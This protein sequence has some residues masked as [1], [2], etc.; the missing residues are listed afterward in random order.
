[1]EVLNAA[2]SIHKP[3]ISVDRRTE[4]KKVFSI[5]SSFTFKYP[6]SAKFDAC[7]LNLADVLSRGFSGGLVVLSSV[8]SGKLAEALT[9]EEALEQSM[10]PSTSGVSLDFDV[11]GFVDSIIKF[12]QENPPIV[13]GGAAV[14]AVPLILAQVLK[15]TKN[16]GVESAGS[17]Y[18]KLSEDPDAQLLDIRAPGEFRE[19]GGPDIRGLKKKAVSIVYKRDDKRVFLKKLALKFKEPG[20]TTLLILDKFDG[21][22]ELVAEL[23]TANGFKSAFAVK[24]GAEG[25]RGWMN[26]GLPWLPPKRTLTV[27]FGDLK[28]VISSTLGEGSDALS[29]T[30]GL[31]A[32]AG[33]SLFAFTEIE[34]ILQV[35]GSAAL[36][37][38]VTKRLLFAEDRKVTLQQVD[39]FLNTKVAPKELVDEIKQIGMALLP[40]T[41]NEKPLLPAPVE[42]SP[43][44]SMP[45]PSS[46]E[47]KSEAT[48]EPPPEINS[49][50]KPEVKAETLPGLPR[51]LSPYPYYPDFKPPTSPSPSK[52]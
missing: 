42:G 28:D 3:T 17:A 13:A 43:E 7:P 50:P 51:P 46:P 15:K 44:T 5:P 37:Q 29:T 34:T 12:G 20:N 19:V 8:F 21:N 27:D 18:S 52:P 36:V 41:V 22:S 10:S 24:D 33:L 25:T 14:L 38:L 23:V 11:G 1:M 39:E 48:A 30:I 49:V 26:S 35:L 31:A 47:P 6:K 9:Y 16:W 4:P 45:E 40:V 2:V 32:V